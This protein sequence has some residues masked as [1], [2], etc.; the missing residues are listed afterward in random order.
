MIFGL[1]LC[2]H[3]AGG[4]STVGQTPHGVQPSA[5]LSWHVCVDF[6]EKHVQAV[7]AQAGEMMV[8]RQLLKSEA[9]E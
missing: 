7:L 8:V 6:K 9:A 3:D 2:R 5:K 4:W 1:N